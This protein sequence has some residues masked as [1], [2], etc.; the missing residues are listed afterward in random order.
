VA[1]T[2]LD[3]RQDVVNLVSLA[4]DSATIKE[5]VLAQTE[6]LGEVKADVREI[7]TALASAVHRDEY[8]QRH[9]EVVKTAQ[10]ALDGVIELKTTARNWRFVFTAALA[11]LGAVIAYLH[12]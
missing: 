6:T 1:D 3:R 9:K 5:R 2:P 10:A 4:V 7:K 11:S 12:H 8:E